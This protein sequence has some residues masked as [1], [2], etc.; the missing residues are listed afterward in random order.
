MQN[1]F[2]ILF[3]LNATKQSTEKRVNSCQTEPF[4]SPY[5]RTNIDR[6][7]WELL[8]ALSVLFL[9]KQLPCH[10]VYPLKG[11]P[12]FYTTVTQTSRMSGL[13]HFC[14]CF[15][16]FCFEFLIF[17]QLS[18]LDSC[19]AFVCSV[20]CSQSSLV[21]LWAGS[22]PLPARL[23]CRNQML[24]FSPLNVLCRSMLNTP[25]LWIRLRQLYL[26]QV[27]LARLKPLVLCIVELG[28]AE[29]LCGS[30]GV[31][32]L[33]SKA[34][35]FPLRFVI[36]S[37]LSWLLAALTMALFSSSSLCRLCTACCHQQR[38][39]SAVILPF[40]WI[41]VWLSCRSPS[42]ATSSASIW[43]SRHSSTRSANG[44]RRPHNASCRS[45]TCADAVSNISSS[46]SSQHWAGTAKMKDL[47]R[48]CRLPQLFLC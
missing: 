33:V 17:F 2:L 18:C 7:V 29:G 46:A 40:Q 35:V 24:T 36:S 41:S 37:L 11:F 38:S 16:G 45:S 14:F 23:R 6:Y 28:L 43:C 22:C 5:P 34:A 10:A 9:T 39:F 15:G 31:L 3:N 25:G 30:L 48:S 42:S 12:A 26:W 8:D 4:C 32:L 21:V 13:F 1:S 20:F 19:C 47:P 44:P 27:T